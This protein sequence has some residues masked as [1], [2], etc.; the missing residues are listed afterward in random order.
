MRIAL[1]NL[2]RCKPNGKI[3]KEKNRNSNRMWYFRKGNEIKHTIRLRKKPQINV[4]VISVVLILLSP[5]RTILRYIV[6]VSDAW[7][8]FNLWFCA[9][10]ARPTIRKIILSG[11]MR[12]PTSTMLSTQLKVIHNLCS[13]G[14]R[15]G[16]KIT[17]V[18][19]YRKTN[20]SYDDC[21]SVWVA[22]IE[23]T[24]ELHA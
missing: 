17:I 20:K 3:E 22:C 7:E 16:N 19:I 2:V 23:R 18:Q 13:R 5:L 11:T 21:E 6:N 24:H 9:I 14:E 1:S 8:Q 10:S 4:F 15:N 12:W